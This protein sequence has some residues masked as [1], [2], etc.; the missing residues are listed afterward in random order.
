MSNTP[1][2]V[3]F[4]RRRCPV[5]D[6]DRQKSQTRRGG[7]KKQGAADSTLD[8]AVDIAVGIAVDIAGREARRAHVVS[9]HTQPTLRMTAFTVGRRHLLQHDLRRNG[10]NSGPI[11]ARIS[12]FLCLLQR[13]LRSRVRH[14]GRAGYSSHYRGR[15][16][17]R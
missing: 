8:I 5:R 1:H 15:T 4:R 16:G 12:S 9:S 13:V 11:Y 7:T 17:F 14:G 3:G 6:R 2:L 10:F